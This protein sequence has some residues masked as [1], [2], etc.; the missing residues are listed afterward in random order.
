VAKSP[1]VPKALKDAA[2]GL[3]FPSET[4]APV[5]AFAWPAGPITA[6]GVRAAVGVD[7][8]AKVEELTAAEFFR[9]LPR[10]LRADYFNLL[11]A[12][13]DHLTGVKVFKVGET[14]MT[15]YLVGS[16]V[17]GLRAGVKTVVVET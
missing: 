15:V 1:A 7:S 14:R 11:L 16:T 9:A 13:V 12:F 4:D 10:E 6:A 8:K 2:R 3:A 5:E 17:D